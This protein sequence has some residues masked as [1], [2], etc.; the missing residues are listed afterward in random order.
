MLTPITP[1]IIEEVKNRLVK[2][3]NPLE[4]YLYGPHA[5]GTTDPESD[6]DLAVIVEEAN[7]PNDA[8]EVDG[9]RALFGL[10]VPKEIIVY[11]KQ[12]FDEESQNISCFGYNI[13][14][15]G[16]RIYAKS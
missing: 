6:L 13:K 3:Y 2:T 15:L 4:I 16:K 7:F 11:T 8:R 14:R 1:E 10:G 12:E 5:Y 9:Y